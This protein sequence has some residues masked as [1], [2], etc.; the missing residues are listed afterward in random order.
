[1]SII[2]IVLIFTFFITSADSAPMCCR[3]SLK[4]GRLIPTNGKKVVWGAIVAG[5]AMAL[6]FAGGLKA[7]QSTLI[8]IAL[9][10]AVVIALIVVALIVEVYHEKVQMGLSISP[11]RYP[12]KGQ[13]FKSYEPYEVEDSETI[14]YQK[15]SLKQKWFKKNHKFLAS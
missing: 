9:P 5:I 13:P 15:K 12:E 3:C 11:K 8:I 14:R 7:L 1:M 10:F 2:A 6:L 4:M